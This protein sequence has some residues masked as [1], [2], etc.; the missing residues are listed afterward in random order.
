M[1]KMLAIVAVLTFVTGAMAATVTLTD[2]GV[3]ENGLVTVGYTYDGEDAP[4]AFGLVVDSDVS[5]SAVTVPAFYDVFIDSA[6]T[7]GDGYT[8]PG[9]GT[10]TGIPTAQVGVAGELALP[11]TDF[12]I[13][14]GGLKDGDTDLPP[15]EEVDQFFTLQIADFGS[16]A[17]GT[18]DIVIAAD[19]VRGGVVS[20]AGAFDVVGTTIT[21][22]VEGGAIVGDVNGDAAINILDLSALT[23]A[24]VADGTP[25]FYVITGN[26][27]MDING[28]GTVNILDLSALTN[29]LVAGGTPPFYTIPNI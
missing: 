4:V 14:A 24:L 28:D 25:P 19:D 7:L 2:G 10:S 1:K 13:S 6:Y 16:L 22:T 18:Y 20:E 3:D 21:V 12:A 29:A 15:A 9:E 5:I 8:Y 27:A 17:E 11:A 23:N 26:A